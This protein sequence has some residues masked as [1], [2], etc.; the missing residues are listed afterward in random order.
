VSSAYSFSARV[1]SN[2][3][4]SFTLISESAA[5]TGSTTA[6]SS[7]VLSQSSRSIKDQKVFSVIESSVL[8]YPS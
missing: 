1:S 8:R 7:P 2:V 3:S 4:T 6:S 5:T